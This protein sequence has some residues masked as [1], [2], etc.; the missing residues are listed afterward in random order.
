VQSRQS[1][2]DTTEKTYQSIISTYKFM[3]KSVAKLLASEGLTQPQFYALRF[4]SKHGPVKMK[5]LSD[6]LQVTPANVTGVIDRLESRGLIKRTAQRGDRRATLLVLTAKGK[7]LHSRV[8]RRYAEFV[9]GSLDVF[10]DDEKRNLM[11]L[12]ERLQKEMSRRDLADSL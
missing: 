8:R 11:L 5:E 7:A 1:V 2:S 6:E 9:Q 3:Q 4:V 10:T 12:L